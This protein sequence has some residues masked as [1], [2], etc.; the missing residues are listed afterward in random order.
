ML[1]STIPPLT[2]SELAAK[3]LENNSYLPIILCSGYSAKISEPEAKAIGIHEFCMKPVDLPKLSQMARTTLDQ[4]G[5]AK[6]SR[7][8]LESN[9]TEPEL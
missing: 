9:L 6:A 2:G 4:N 8:L 5:K 1:R 7:L 3:I